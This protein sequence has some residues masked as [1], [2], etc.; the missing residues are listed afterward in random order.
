MS[1]LLRKIQLTEYEMLKEIDRIA[2]KA[3][4][5]SIDEEK[6]TEEAK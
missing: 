3:N 1:D 5:P 2:K 4:E 6:E